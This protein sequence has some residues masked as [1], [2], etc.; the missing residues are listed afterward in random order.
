MT[1]DP[2]QQ[3][4]KIWLPS[5]IGKLAVYVFVVAVMV[6]SIFLVGNFQSFLDETQ[7]LLLTV[8]RFASLLLV[9]V[10]AAYA[11]VVIVLRA[12][13]GRRLSIFPFVLAVAG[14]AGFLALHLLVTF[15]LAWVNPVN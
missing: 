15:L 14:G 7:V 3:H 12:R 4:Q 11:V 2:N 9:V 1:E 5:V 10:A 8:F 13:T 6:L